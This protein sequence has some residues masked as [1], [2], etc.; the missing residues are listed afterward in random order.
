MIDVLPERDADTAARV[1]EALVARADPAALTAAL[2]AEDDE[3]LDNDDR[4]ALDARAQTSP[5][6]YSTLDDVMR[7][8][9]DGPPSSL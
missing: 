6:D 3:P 7:E 5:D 1:L 4:S 9:G 8:L 2:A